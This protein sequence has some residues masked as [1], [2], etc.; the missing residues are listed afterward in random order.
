M[1]SRVF[2]VVVSISLLSGLMPL[3]LPAT[4]AAAEKLK[5][6]ATLWQ[7]ESLCNFKDPSNWPEKSRM[8]AGTSF[9]VTGCG[10]LEKSLGHPSAVLVSIE[11]PGAAE[12]AV[13]IGGFTDIAAKSK[14]KKNVR[15]LAVY[16][17]VPSP[18]GDGYSTGFSTKFSG[19]W[20]IFIE[21]G[22]SVDLVFLF[23]QVNKGDAITVGKLPAAKV[24]GAPPSATAAQR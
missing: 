6:R 10:D 9:T 11:S 5:T 16:R 24:G 23:P 22:K 8:D 2:A 3:S 7:Y 1:R 20:T 17:R 19:R 4:V 13:A 14:G 12:A 15:P 21:P 18:L